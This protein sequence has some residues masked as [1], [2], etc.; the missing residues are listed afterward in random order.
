MVRKFSALLLALLV[1]VSGARAEDEAKIQA[2]R[3]AHPPFAAAMRALGDEDAASAIAKLKPLTSSADNA[4]AA[5][6]AYFLGRAYLI[7][8]QSEEA[9]PTFQRVLGEHAAHTSHAA[10]ARFFL[11]VCQEQLLLRRQALATFKQFQEEHPDAPERMQTSAKQRIASLR[12]I[13][14][15]ELADVQTRMEYVRRRLDIGHSGRRTQ[16]EQDNIIAMLDKLLEENPPHGPTPDDPP[17]G[18]PRSPDDEGPPEEPGVPREGPGSPKPGPK[19]GPRGKHP[20]GDGAESGNPDH[21]LAKLARR[22]GSKRDDWSQVRDHDRE[23]KA[24]EALRQRFPSRYA[25]LVKQYY[26]SLAED[27][28]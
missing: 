23:T 24:L 10:E 5:E 16:D 6:S 4:L 28:E 19:G 13:G 14:D 1:S 11:G 20:G 8:E 7:H 12:T 22:T 21:P 26:R 9:L 3:E 27:A 18:D 17:P 2:L 25:E 15:G